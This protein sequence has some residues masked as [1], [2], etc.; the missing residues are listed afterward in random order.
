MRIENRVTVGK[1][2]TTENDAHDMAQE[3]I[4]LAKSLVRMSDDELH[5]AMDIAHEDMCK[6]NDELEDARLNRE[7]H[8]MRLTVM[9]Y[10]QVRRLICCE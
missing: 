8:S 3:A 1:L 10:E 6:A 2:E 7:L 5:F 9:E 4:E